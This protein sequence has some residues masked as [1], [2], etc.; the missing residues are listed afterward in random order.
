MTVFLLYNSRDRLEIIAIL[1]VFSLAQLKLCLTPQDH[2]LFKFYKI[3]G[4]VI[5][6]YKDNFSKIVTQKFF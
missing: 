3:S 2:E 6:Y 5:N 4:Q 1:S